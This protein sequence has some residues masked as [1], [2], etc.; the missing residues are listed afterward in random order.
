MPSDPN[1][2]LVVVC[3]SQVPLSSLH[4]NF[5]EDFKI[6]VGDMLTEVDYVFCWIYWGH[7][8]CHCHC[9]CQENSPPLKRRRK[10]SEDEDLQEPQR[11]LAKGKEPYIKCQLVYNWK[12]IIRNKKEAVIT[13]QHNIWW[14]QIGS[15]SNLNF[16]FQSSMSWLQFPQY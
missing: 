5:R 7:A 13:I 15:S 16:N 6:I 4:M 9:H 14:L 8:I 1:M 10:H 2:C 12:Q 11:G 3:T